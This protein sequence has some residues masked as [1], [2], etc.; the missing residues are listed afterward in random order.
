M[1]MSENADIPGRDTGSLD[2]GAH[3]SGCE[4]P[5][6]VPDDMLHV[7]ICVDFNGLFYLYQVGCLKKMWQLQ[8]ILFGNKFK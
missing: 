7:N 3:H 5:Q 4:M 8:E 2:V 6:P 1:R